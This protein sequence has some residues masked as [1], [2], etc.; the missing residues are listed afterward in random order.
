MRGVPRHRRAISS[1][2]S[3]AWAP[4]PVNTN[5]GD[6]GNDFL[7]N[8]RG[9]RRPSENA[10]I[11]RN[12]RVGKEARYNL[13]IRGEFVNIFNRTL[14][15]SPSTTSPQNPDTRNA[16]GY[17]TSGFGVVNAYQTPGTA[18]IFAGGTAPRTG[19]VVARF[20]F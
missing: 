13:Q 14:M 9:P 15:P 16:L 3:A 11:G 18:T 20:S 19:T 12:F 1:A 2:A 7:K 6:S 4:C 10:G 17:L 8:F 5:C